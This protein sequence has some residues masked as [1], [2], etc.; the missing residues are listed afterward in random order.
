MKVTLLT[1][2]IFL[3]GISLQVHAQATATKICNPNI[4]R[5][6]SI[7]SDADG[8][9]FSGYLKEVLKKVRGK[10]YRIMPQEARS[11]INK[12]GC[13]TI[14]FSVQ[15]NGKIQNLEIVEFSGDKSLDDAARNGILAC[16]HF[17]HL[18]KQYPEKNLKLRSHFYYNVAKTTNMLN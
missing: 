5:P 15:K 11:P 13:V 7:V 1:Y 18:P 4:I 6:D 3:L 14:E 9:N 8:V 16:H 17:Q 12:R 10:W 2:F